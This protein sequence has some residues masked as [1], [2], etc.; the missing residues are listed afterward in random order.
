[1]LGS[2]WPTPRLPTRDLLRPV[3]P[4]LR[5]ADIAF[6]NLEGVL[7]DGGTVRPDKANPRRHFAFRT[8]AR[9]ALWLERAGLD[10]LSVANNHAGD[11]QAAGR[12]ATLRALRA[13]HLIP[14]GGP[15]V[16]RATKTVH[17]VPVTF[18]GFSTGGASPNLNRIDAAR[19]L[20]TFLGTAPAR[21]AMTAEGVE[22]AR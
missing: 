13:H 17:G 20:V 3:A 1:M 16:L 12:A 19:A 11:F 4:L 15:G 21:A 9:Y 14:V 5:D 6:G 18:L 2:D 8:P 22:A 7:A 10:V